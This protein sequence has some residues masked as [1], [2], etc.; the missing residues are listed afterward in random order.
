MADSRD[1]VRLQQLLD[2]YT[3]LVKNEF[4]SEFLRFIERQAMDAMR[5]CATETYNENKIRYWQGA[6]K[7]LELTYKEFPTRLLDEIKKEIDK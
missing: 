4:F 2:D 6:Y 1:R 3:E 7:A 5:R